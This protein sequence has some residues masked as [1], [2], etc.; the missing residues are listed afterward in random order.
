M[1]EMSSMENRFSMEGGVD[2]EKIYNP[3]QRGFGVESVD[4]FF[5]KI[6]MRN[7]E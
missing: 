1:K 4:N 6:H 7:K 5:L 2:Y 3:R